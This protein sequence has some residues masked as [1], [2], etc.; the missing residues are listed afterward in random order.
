MK[1]EKDML[2]QE[3]SGDTDIKVLK[4]KIKGGFFSQNRFSGLCL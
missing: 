1:N 2:R 3:R 4:K